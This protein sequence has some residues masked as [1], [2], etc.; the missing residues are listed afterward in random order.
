MP[1]KSED[2]L[3]PKTFNNVDGYG[4]KGHGVDR[5]G[6]SPISNRQ[7]NDVQEPGFG[8]HV[9]RWSLWQY[10]RSVHVARGECFIL[11]SFSTV[12]R[13]ERRR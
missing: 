7:S 13:A 8:H 1:Y 12:N 4:G 9:I 3:Q 5:R 11:I 6:K 10:G 2:M